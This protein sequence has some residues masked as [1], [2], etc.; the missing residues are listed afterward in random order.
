MTTDGRLK[1]VS[2]SENDALVRDPSVRKIGKEGKT[3]EQTTAWTAYARKRVAAGAHLSIPWL[4]EPA[5]RRDV[6]ADYCLDCS[7]L[8]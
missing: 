4:F 8:P 6:T 3:I 1:E 7:F 5:K 2:S